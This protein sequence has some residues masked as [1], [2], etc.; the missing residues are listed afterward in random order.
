MILNFIEESTYTPVGLS[1]AL[2]RTW[3]GTVE[4]NSKQQGRGE[5]GMKSI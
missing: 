2:Y 3:R 4:I 5:K 1:F